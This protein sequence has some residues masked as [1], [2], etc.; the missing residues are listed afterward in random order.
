MIYYPIHNM[1]NVRDIG[2]WKGKDQRFILP[3]RFLRSDRPKS[4]S[5]E[6]ASFLKEHQIQDIIDLRTH[7]VIQKLPNPL[8]DDPYFNY[9]HLPLEEGS[10]ISLQSM[11]PHELYNLMVEH[12]DTFYQIFSIFA[13]AEH[14]VLVHCTAGKDRTGVV[15]A[16]LLE[17]LGVDK[18]IIIG[19]YAY[20]SLILDGNY[21]SY[22][23]NHPGFKPFLGESNPLYMR[24][25]LSDFHAKYHNAHDYLISIGLKEEELVL[26]EQKAFGL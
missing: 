19:D 8:K 2:L 9:H 11:T 22:Q 17:F 12:K 6:Y 18:D 20:S 25:F 4:D 1:M 24:A 23:K 15:I 3:F 7:Q 5:E 26:I 16:L 14:G 10:T 13:H 21:P